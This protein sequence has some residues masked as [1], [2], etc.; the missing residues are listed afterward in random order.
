MTAPPGSAT[1]FV[2]TLERDGEPVF[3]LSLMGVNG[4]VVVR[5]GPVA[6]GG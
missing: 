5:T 2:A 6:A 1:S 3:V 4:V